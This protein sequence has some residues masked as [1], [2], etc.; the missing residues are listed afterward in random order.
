MY[1]MDGT[2]ETLK[3]SNTRLKGD[4]ARLLSALEAI[5]GMHISEDTDFQ[6]LHALCAAVA[7]TTIK[8][9]QS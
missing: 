6:Q 9:M 7:L 5:G 2:I 3:A 8:E 1:P 4:K